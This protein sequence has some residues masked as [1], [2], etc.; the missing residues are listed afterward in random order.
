MIKLYGN[1][2]LYGNFNKKI[3]NSSFPAQSILYT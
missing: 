3:A 2:Q 1:N